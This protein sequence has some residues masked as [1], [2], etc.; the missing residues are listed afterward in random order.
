[1][2]EAHELLVRAQTEFLTRLA[3]AIEA[4]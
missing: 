1:V 2:P 4:T 3:S